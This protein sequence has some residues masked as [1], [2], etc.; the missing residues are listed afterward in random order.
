MAALPFLSVLLATVLAARGERAET[1]GELLELVDFD[2]KPFTRLEASGVAYHGGRLVVVDDTE[3]E[4]F[5]FDTAGRLVSRLYSAKL[6]EGQ[7]KFEDLAYDEKDGS[8]FAVGSHSGWDEEDLE[9]QSVLIE[10]R[11]RRLEEFEERSIHS[12][13][14]KEPFEVLDMWK[15]RT[16]KIEGLAVDD[17]S[18]TLY[19]GLRE[20]V[21]RARIY[22]MG[23]EGLRKGEPQME[24]ALEFDAGFAESTP[25]CV[26]GLAWDSRS[27]GLF[28]TTS[29]EDDAT[30]AFLGN[31]LWH[32][33]PGEEPRLLLDRFDRGRK[34]EGLA[35]G[36][37]RLF[38]VYDN[39]QDDTGLASELRVIPMSELS[40]KGLATP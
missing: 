2:Q 35:L 11:L 21:D 13:P 5:L 39:D 10:F 36:A 7:A 37:D 28:I 38:I 32:W 9:R 24:L 29:T 23:L 6:P 22:R 33:I 3:N 1:P 18:N 15:P 8:Y 12:L 26:A 31:R 16:M 25:Y 19:V 40:V 14:L 20:P 4:L 17:R 27:G 30:H 34:A